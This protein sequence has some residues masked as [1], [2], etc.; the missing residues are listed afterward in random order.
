MIL[1]HWQLPGKGPLHSHLFSRLIRTVRN[2]S[3]TVAVGLH[4]QYKFEDPGFLCYKRGKKS[5]LLN[6]AASKRSK[7]GCMWWHAGKTTENYSL[8]QGRDLQNPAW[9][10]E[11]LLFRAYSSQVLRRNSLRFFPYLFLHR[12]NPKYTCGKIQT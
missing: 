3:I 6:V 7:G 2:Q 11:S 12:K 9:D 5:N 4:S 8:L 10:Q 1:L